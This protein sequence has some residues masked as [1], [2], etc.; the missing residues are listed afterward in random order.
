MGD[1]GGLLHDTMLVAG[2][3]SDD[4]MAPST[5]SSASKRSRLRSLAKRTKQKTKTILNLDKTPDSDPGSDVEDGDIFADPAFNPTIV[6][7]GDPA[8]LSL[9]AASNSKDKL[10]AAGDVIAHP[11]RSVRNKVTRTAAGKISTVQRPF[12]SG[13]HDR[14]LLAA[15]DELNEALSSQS[16]ARGGE[17][18]GWESD[19]YQ[20]RQKVE[21]VEEARESAK[22]AWAI[23][24]HVQRVRVMEKISQR[25]LKQQ[26]IENDPS[27]QE[28]FRWDVWIAKLTLYYT[29]GFTAQYIDDFEEPVFDIEDFARIVERISMSSAPWQA[30]LIDVRLVYLWEDAQRT[31]KWM[32]LFWTLWYTEHLVGFLYAYI[33]Y[34]VLRNRLYPDTVEAVRQAYTRSV[35]QAL[36][37]Q[38]WG[39]LV[40]KHGH[41]D[42]IEP[43][44]DDMG[45]M[46]QLQLAD[47]ADY[48]EVLTNFYKWAWPR[49]TAASLFFFSVCLL[50]SLVADMAF[51]VKIVWFIV[52]SSFFLT[53]PIATRFPQYRRLLSAWRWFVWDI[54]TDAEWS[55]RKL[56]EKALVRQCDIPS[57]HERRG[58]KRHDGDSPSDYST[59]ESSPTR[60]PARIARESW[61][62]RVYQ[63]AK[64]GS[65]VITRK[66]LTFKLGPTPWRIPFV[67][68]VEMRKTQTAK[69]MK[70]RA[71]K[72]NLEAI[73]FCYL[74]DAD[75]EQCEVLSMAEEIRHE[76]FSLVLGL[77]GLRWRA[78]QI[79]RHN[80]AGD[81]NKSHLDRVFK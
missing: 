58:K 10:K 35:D 49:K 42:W 43:L 45:P 80:K 31:G 69:K 56:Q 38:A 12:L 64:S 14:D 15:H 3:D 30:W 9:S 48:L 72:P 5:T 79:V 41:E 16:S 52:G 66:G 34:T 44:L 22:I 37:A 6:L 8:R 21:K 47:A 57:M 55:I 61:R 19:E 11:R 25:P 17:T 68:L 4:E 28:N 70:V 63:G 26:F 81:E 67:R 18:S 33:I 60:L 1:N 36:K 65:L 7:N 46:I 78:L 51:C 20:A 24:R 54:P 75:L 77:S 50:I 76:V 29:Q 73:E 2:S 62:F 27:G 53:Y 32:I 39:E 40:E 23:G 59:P 71:L 74:D 13:N